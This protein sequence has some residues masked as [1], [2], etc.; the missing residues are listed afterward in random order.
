MLLRRFTQHIKAQ[1]WLGVWLDLII[2]VLGIF[3]GLQVSNINSQ[4]IANND[5]NAYLQDLA[6]EFNNSREMKLNH[7]RWQT[8]VL[9]GLQLALDTLDGFTPSEEQLEH[10]YFSLS[11]LDSPPPLPDRKEVL[12]EMQSTGKIQLLPRDNLRSALLESLALYK[13]GKEFFKREM[14]VISA[15]QFSSSIVTWEIRNSSN[16][17]EEGV[18]DIK[19]IDVVRARKST[20]F[21]LRI[22]QGYALFS[23]I[24]RMNWSSHQEDT[25]I[26]NML[27]N[28]GFTSK[29][30]WS[31]KNLKFLMSGPKDNDWKKLV[32]PM[33]SASNEQ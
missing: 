21:R 33:I 11:V 20:E 19:N 18:L 7:I 1:N 25:L 14:A 3:L 22:L 4:R 8:R 12:I 26:L 10:I 29:E 24:R 32:D 23:S 30:N 31:K 28:K 27:H 2:V 9:E 6:T 13:L 16:F 5:L 17:R 15:P